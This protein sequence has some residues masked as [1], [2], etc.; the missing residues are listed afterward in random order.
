LYT[1]RVR[2]AWIREALRSDRRTDSPADLSAGGSTDTASGLQA[3]T[4]S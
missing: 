3:P 2:L 1:Q 4:E